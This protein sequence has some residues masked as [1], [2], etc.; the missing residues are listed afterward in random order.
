MGIGRESGER[1]REVERSGETRGS[2]EGHMPRRGEKAH[3][4]EGKTGGTRQR[5]G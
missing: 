3:A 1:R 5:N 2:G 4:Q